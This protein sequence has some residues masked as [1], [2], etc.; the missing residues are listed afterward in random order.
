MPTDELPISG[1]IINVLAPSLRLRMSLADGE[2]DVGVNDRYTVG[3]SWDKHHE[4]ESVNISPIIDNTVE[5][6]N[7]A[8]A[9]SVLLELNDFVASSHHSSVLSDSSR[10][11]ST[12][13]DDSNIQND[14]NDALD[15]HSSI[16]ILPSSPQLR[17]LPHGPRIAYLPRPAHLKTHLDI[18]FV[19]HEDES[20]FNGS[21][22]PAALVSLDS[23]DETSRN[24]RRINDPEGVTSMISFPVQVFPQVSQPNTN[25]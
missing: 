15:D 11:F 9:N 7:D 2:S 3:T 4:G 19:R 20:S 1:T 24:S 16:P 25:L 13:P 21:N 10:F 5:V 18:S 8:F 23:S 17:T 6:V 22:P 12:P 14:A